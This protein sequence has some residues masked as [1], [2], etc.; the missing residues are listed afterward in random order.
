MRLVVVVVVCG[1]GEVSAQPNPDPS[2]ATD[3]S[4][5][6]LAPVTLPSNPQPATRSPYAPLEPRPDGFEDHHG[7]TIE[8]NLG[9]GGMHVTNLSSSPVNGFGFGGL[10]LGIGAFVVPRVALTVRIAGASA[11]LAAPESTIAVSAYYG[12]AVQVWLGPELWVGGGFGPAFYESGTTCGLTANCIT[13]GWGLD[14]RA[15]Y[16]FMKL[17]RHSFDVSAEVTPA[18]FA[19]DAASWRMIGI[20]VLLGYQFL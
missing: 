16:T 15:G 17:A 14:M 20:G 7:L 4:A 5:P 3:P 8:A 11:R 19:N 1:F 9:I 10:D 6:P 18:F 13:Q 2:P 12:A